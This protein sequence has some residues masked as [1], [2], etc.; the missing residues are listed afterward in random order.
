MGAGTRCLEFLSLCSAVLIIAAS[1]CGGGAADPTGSTERTPAADV[2]TAERAYRCEV[3]PRRFDVV[4]Q[5]DPGQ[6]AWALR[7]LEDALRTLVGP[8]DKLSVVSASGRILLPTTALP[9]APSDDCMPDAAS[10][11]CNELGR[12]QECQRSREER[13]NAARA[14]Q[15]AMDA[16]ARAFDEAWQIVVDAAGQSGR[17]SSWSPEAGCGTSSGWPR[18]QLQNFVQARVRDGGDWVIILHACQTGDPA[19]LP[20]QPRLGSG[21]LEGAHLVIFG[22]LSRVDAAKAWFDG[23]GYR[24]IAVLGPTEANEVD[25]AVMQA[26]VPTP[27]PAR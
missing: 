2:S 5:D 24:S 6:A 12:G 18:D 22:L 16:A 8:G 19:Q 14:A 15:A 25:D 23:T 3:R 7:Y 17:S 26:L 11:A 4:L 27:T 20:D 1:G 10:V 13:D 9:G 21:S